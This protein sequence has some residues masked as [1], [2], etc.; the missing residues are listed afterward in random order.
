MVVLDKSSPTQ[1]T[2]RIVAARRLCGRIATYIDTR[3]DRS[4]A[5]ESYRGGESKIPS[6][7]LR[8]WDT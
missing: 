2:V 8:E 3:I 7:S 6:W 5:L 1:I 4:S